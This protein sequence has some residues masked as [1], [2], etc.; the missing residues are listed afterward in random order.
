VLH[1]ET[2][3][4][5]T[6]HVCGRCTSLGEQ[7]LLLYRALQRSIDAGNDRKLRGTEP[8]LQSSGPG[9]VCWVANV[10]VH[11][12]ASDEA[13]PRSLPRRKPSS[14]AK[15]EDGLGALRNFLPDELLEPAAISTSGDG[16]DLRHSRGHARFRAKTGRGEDEAWALRLAAHIPTR[17]DVV[18][19]TFR[20]R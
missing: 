10:A 20:L 19:E 2:C 18:F 11:D 12:L 8:R 6:L 15:A 16:S 4:D 1:R 3:N 9:L 5:V 14:N 7:R 17:T 13:S